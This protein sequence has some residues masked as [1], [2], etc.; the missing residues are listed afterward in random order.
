MLFLVVINFSFAKPPNSKN[1]IVSLKKELDQYSGDYTQQL[2]IL[3]SLSISYRK[4]SPDSSMYY[5][6]QALELSKKMKSEKEKGDALQNLG[7]AYFYANDFKKSLDYLYQSLKIREKM[8][9]SDKIGH[10]L[11]SIANVY[12]NLNNVS[13]AL[14]FYKRSLSLARKFGD[15][16]REASILINMG[17]LYGSNG[18]IDTAYVLLNQSVDLLENLHDSPALSTS[19]NNLALLYRKNGAYEKSLEYD[20]KALRINK[21]MGRKWEISY[22]SNSIGETYLLMKKYSKAFEYFNEALSAAEAL[23]NQDILLF[24]YRSMTKYYSAVGNYQQ[25]HY[26]FYKYEATKDAIFTNQNTNSIAEMQVK[27]E[28]ERKEKEYA[29]QKL[30]IAKERTIKNSFIFLSI[31]ILIMVVILFFRFRVKKKLSSELEILVKKRTN[32]LLVNQSKLTEAQRIGKSGSWDWDLVNNRLSWSDELPIIL[33]R[34][35]SDMNWVAILRSTHEEDRLKIL[36]IL[37]RKFSE[38]DSHLVFDFRITESGTIEKY[39]SVY[40]EVIKD[41]SGNIKLVQG[42]IQDITERKIAEI[43][44]IESEQWYR[45]LI[46]ASPDAVFKINADGLIVFAS[47]Q[48]RTLFRIS[49][50]RVIIGTHINEWIVKTDQLRVMENLRAQGSEKSTSDTHV[51]LQRKDGSTFSGELRTAKISDSDGKSKGLIVVVRNITYRKQ[52]E[53]HIL[54][55][56][57]ETEERERQRFSE[58]LHDGLGP[59]LSTAKI[60][61][62]LIAARME[63]PIEQKE[64]IKMTDD[65]LY[66]SIKST[67]EIANNLAPNLLNDF[68]LIETLSVYVDKINKMNSISVDLKIDQNFP[69]LRK[70][71]EIAFYRIISEL[72][73]NTLKHASASKIEIELLK[74]QGQVEITYSDNG[75]G[76]DIQKMLS[77]PSKGLGLS[78]ITSRVKSINGYC[79]FNS[80]PGQ[81]FRTYISV[82][83][84]GELEH[85]TINTSLKI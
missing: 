58:D 68:G 39:I 16:K 78:N 56:T 77:S 29:L 55:N 53:Q 38:F 75:I 34:T 76:C 43:A 13:E 40:A 3:N 21:E 52:M 20:E 73:N 33:G 11:N 30:Q 85:R 24:S 14:K 22:I 25:F 17:S 31:L 82:A 1:V 79:K 15:K 9:D 74:T 28:T 23:Q 50:E 5:A 42:N 46:S 26:Y 84:S 64:F 4:V 37:R 71:T 12:F 61:L 63:K 57:I 81:Y 18:R 2:S 7:I 70:Q 67:R 83:I 62:E 8:A 19:Y 66:E 47:Q 80:V 60:Y 27:Y 45:K 48:S 35:N 10:T 44:L 41:D 49:D 59:L 6:K 51:V 54:R 36:K 72:L 32:D 69:V 65:I